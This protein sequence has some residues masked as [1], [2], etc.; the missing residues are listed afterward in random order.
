[1]HNDEHK[2]FGETQDVL[3]VSAPQRACCGAK[4]K[5]PWWLERKKKKCRSCRST[6]KIHCRGGRS[7]NNFFGQLWT[8]VHLEQI[9]AVQHNVIGDSLRKQEA[10][11]LPLYPSIFSG[12]INYKL[13]N[14]RA[15]VCAP[16]GE[17][18]ELL[19]QIERQE[20]VPCV[21]QATGRWGGQEH[22]VPLLTEPRATFHFQKPCSQFSKTS[23]TLPTLHHDGWSL[24]SIDQK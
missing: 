23:H 6:S 12:R 22:Q 21:L 14:N 17:P 5:I 18:V 9:S 13:Q 2:N 24:W 7:A 11:S 16:V 20:V 1:M 15:T 4:K 10:R 8:T 3:I 19:E